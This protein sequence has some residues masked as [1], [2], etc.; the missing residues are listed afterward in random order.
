MPSNMHGFLINSH[1]QNMVPSM[2][3][4]PFDLLILNATVIDGPGLIDIKRMW[5]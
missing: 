1:N 5:R 2:A 4:A 3:N